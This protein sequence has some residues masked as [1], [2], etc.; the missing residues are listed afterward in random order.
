MQKDKIEIKM[1]NHVAVIMDGNG[2]WAKLRRLPRH[3]GHKKG[4]ETAKNVITWCKES[5]IKFVSLFVFSTENWKRPE[6]EVNE[7]FALADKYLSSITDFA[8]DD[9]KIL[10]SGEINGLPN[11]LADKIILAEQK[12]AKN[13]G[14]TVN[15]CINYG[16]QAEIVSLANKMAEKGM[17]LTE[18]QFTAAICGQLPSLDFVVRTGGQ[19]RVSN[20]MLYQMAYAELL[21]L[22]TLWPDFDK[23]D[24]DDIINVYSNR[25]RNFGGIKE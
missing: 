16:G 14:C 13:K 11:N 7:L 21:F 4:L 20:F 6:K 23:S 9:V 3:E 10:H 15:L 12:T 17:Q 22:D 25:A 18:A 2:R 1:P 5:G 8:S 19:M 24:F